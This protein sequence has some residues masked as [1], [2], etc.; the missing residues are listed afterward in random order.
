MPASCAIAAAVAALS[1]VSITTR[2]PSPS[3]A[4]PPRATIRAADRQWPA[5]PARR[6]RRARPRLPRRLQRADPIQRQVDIGETTPAHRAAAAPVDNVPSTPLPG[7]AARKSA[8]LG[9]AP[10]LRALQDRARQ[11]MLGALLQAGRE[12]KRSSDAIASGTRSVTTGSPRVSVPVLSTASTLDLLGAFQRLGVLDQDAGAR[13]LPGA[14]HDRRRRRQAER[15]RAGDD[16][17]GHGVDQRRLNSP[18][19][20]T[21]SRRRSPARSRTTGTKIA[22]MRSARR[23]TGALEPC[24]FGDH[25]DDAGQQRVFADAGGRQRSMPS[26]LAVAAKTRSPAALATGMLSPVSIA[27]LTPTR[28]R[29]PR[30][31]PAPLSPGRTMKMSPGISR[32]ASSSTSWPSRSTR[33]VFGCR[34]TS[35]SIAAV[36]RAL[37]R[38]SSSLPSSTS[39]ITAA[40]ASKYTCRSWRTRTSVTNRLKT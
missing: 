9:Q 35:A 38:A 37:A 30:R 40:E 13:A 10:T 19:A 31:R 15:A 20:T 8:E 12:R 27:S 24:A 34:R 4:P 39:V 22:E 11:R 6:L 26:P 18:P 5:A 29:A 36:V 25:A 28:R 1:P 7:T 16:Q 23:C 17:H 2:S 21:T 3:G 33:A 32:P 14:D